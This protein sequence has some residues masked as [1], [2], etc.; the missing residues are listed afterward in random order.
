[1]PTVSSAWA[2]WQRWPRAQS[3]AGH[4]IPN[5]PEK[6]DFPSSNHRFWWNFTHRNFDPIH[7]AMQNFISVLQIVSEIWFFKL[8]TPWTLS[9]LKFRL[10]LGRVWGPITAQ[11]WKWAFPYFIN[12]LSLVG[13]CKIQDNRFIL[14]ILF[15]YEWCQNG[16]LTNFYLKYLAAQQGFFHL[17]RHIF[18]NSL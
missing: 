4:S 9:R 16:V 17:K 3:I 12:L 5:H 8:V 10:L 13:I 18:F 11:L 15:L 1:M 2:G 7:R 14:G 6:K